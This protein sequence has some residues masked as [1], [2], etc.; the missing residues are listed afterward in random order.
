MKRRK[1]KRWIGC[2]VKLN[3]DG[4]IDWS[5]LRQ[6]PDYSTFVMLPSEYGSQTIRH[7][8]VSYAQDDASV[9]LRFAGPQ[10]VREGEKPRFWHVDVQYPSF[11]IEE[12]DEEDENDDDETDE[13]PQKSFEYLTRAAAE[14]GFER[15]IV[16]LKAAFKREVD[17]QNALIPSRRYE[18]IWRRL[19]PRNNFRDP[20]EILETQ[21]L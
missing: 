18:A 13:P 21:K 5:S 16:K 4:E 1:T 2:A 12:K 6:Q 9:T 14:K 11:S 8:E 20:T 15:E 3:A 10:L 19:K 17:E 7:E